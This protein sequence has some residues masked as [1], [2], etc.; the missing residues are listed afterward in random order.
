VKVVLFGNREFASLAWY[1][2]TNDSPYEVAGFTVDGAYFT[3]PTLHGLP[4]VPFERVEE[5]FPPGDVRLLL[6]IGGDRLNRLRAQKYREAKRKGYAFVSYVSSRAIVWPDLQIGECSMIFEGAIVQ[7]FAK[8]GVGVIIRSGC[9]VSHHVEIGD[10]SFLAA[11]AVTGGRA[12]V[13][14]HCFLGLN[15]VI[16]DNVSVADRCLIGAGA[17]VTADTSE[18]G[19]YIGVPARRQPQPADA[20]NQP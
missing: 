12:K 15:C 18:N 13:G 10:F 4:V 5:R 6:P 1:A 7:P 19:I 8:L 9:H 20:A 16:R 17:V 14:S 11:Q 3:S 2:L